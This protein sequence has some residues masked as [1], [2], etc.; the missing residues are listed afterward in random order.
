MGASV[1]TPHLSIVASI[2]LLGWAVISIP[3][4]DTLKRAGVFPLI[5]APIITTILH[6]G[7]AGPIQLWNIYAAMMFGTHLAFSAFHTLFIARIAYTPPPNDPYPLWTKTR[8]A[9]DLAINKRR[10]GHADQVRD[11]P[12]FSSKNPTSVPSKRSFLACRSTRFILLYILLDLLTLQDLENA[13]TKCAPGQDAILPRLLNNWISGPEFAEL[14]GVT[15]A[16][17]IC[18]VI[19]LTACHDLV[20]VVSVGSGSSVVVDWPPLFGDPRDAYTLRRFWGVF[21]HQQFRIVLT[22]VSGFVVHDVLRFPREKSEAGTGMRMEGLAGR[23]L[24]LFLALML[25]G[26]MHL[27]SD[28]VQG[29]DVRESGAVKFFFWQG[30]GIAIEDIVQAGYRCVTGGK[31]DVKGR[32]RAEKPSVWMRTLGFVW[33]AAYMVLVAPTWM[34]PVLRK[35][36]ATVVP[37]SLVRDILHIKIPGSYHG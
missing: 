23:Y 33:V 30:V 16:Y 15:F 7:N 3:P 22:S 21:W 31:R 36:E 11:V 25:S 32:G 6:A 37:V 10:I 14:I 8:F 13:E 9:L 5:L 2:S 18:G 4:N 20:S 29:V 34:F 26:A 12:P 17:G 24:K 27:N 1:V 35:G 19:G 28:R